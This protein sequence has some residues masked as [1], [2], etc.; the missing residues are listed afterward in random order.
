MFAAVLSAFV[1]LFVTI[2]PIETAAVF[3]ALTAG[4]HRPQRLWLA[5]RA[6]CIAGVLLLIFALGGNLLL[7]L[8]HVSMP[9]FRVAGGLLLFLQALALTFG[10]PNGL[11][12]I[13]QK[14]QREA[15]QP[16]DIA[17]FPLAFPLIAG[18]GALTAV[19]LLMGQGGI[20]HQAIVLAMLAA[21]LALTYGAL[22]IVDHLGRWLGVTGADVVGRVCGVL[23]AALAVQFVFDGVRQAAL[24]E[25]PARSAAG[26]RLN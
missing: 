7:D 21:N 6:V 1:I 17:V 13:S 23:L 24:L 4:I 14:E 2:S 19:V 18:P 5:W 10:S 22:R 20:A 12:G 8:L 9:A 25:P 16:G 15:Q 3:G 26:G 11:S